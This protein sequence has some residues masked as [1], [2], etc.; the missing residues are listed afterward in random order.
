MGGVGECV[1]LLQRGEPGRKP[2]GAADIE[3]PAAD[4]DGAVT[5]G[6]RQET[7]EQEPGAPARKPSRVRR[8]PSLTARGDT[9]W[10]QRARRRAMDARSLRQGV[11]AET[12]A[13][14]ATL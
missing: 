14:R 11:C 8:A 4:S 12:A 6:P 13:C 2:G 7:A 1:A 9:V 5:R 10:A 3:R